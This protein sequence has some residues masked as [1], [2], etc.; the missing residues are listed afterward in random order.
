MSEL[1]S[2]LVV[3]AAIQP[4]GF[5][6]ELGIFR[7]FEL[8]DTRLQLVALAGGG[9]GGIGGSGSRL[10]AVGGTSKRNFST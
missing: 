3:L 5:S 7:R 10:R 2:L 6:G 8:G 1:C 9:I 4:Y